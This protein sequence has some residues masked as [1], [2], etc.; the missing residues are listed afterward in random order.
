MGRERKCYYHL[1]ENYKSKLNL[2]WVKNSLNKV[3]IV[4][5]SGDWDISYPLGNI[6]V[7]F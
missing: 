2:T 5:L 1:T 4:C 3:N 7:Y 6:M